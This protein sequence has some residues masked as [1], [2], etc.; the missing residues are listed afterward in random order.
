MRQ[1]KKI[2]YFISG[3][4]L[5]P[6]CL[7]MAHIPFF[8]AENAKLFYGYFLFVFLLC[9]CL[10][11]LFYRGK[12]AERFPN[13]YAFYGVMYLAFEILGIGLYCLPL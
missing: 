9:Y 2:F 3:G 7:G 1:L 8:G 12:V 6:V 13:R 4:Y 10:F 5:V 11:P